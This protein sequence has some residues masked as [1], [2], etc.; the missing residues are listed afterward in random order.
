MSC[1]EWEQGIII[2]PKPKWAEFR[3]TLIK[4]HNDALISTHA[5]ACAAYD[6][7][8]EKV[9]GM[10]GEGRTKALEDAFAA[11]FG[12][13]PSRLGSG[14]YDFPTKTVG[15]G[16]EAKTT[17]REDEW[18]KCMNVVSDWRTKEWSKPKKKDLGLIPLTGDAVIRLENASIKLVNETHSVTWSVEENNRA[19]DHARQEPLAILLFTLLDKMEWTR[20]SGGKIV[21]NDEYS[22][23]S[24]EYGG[25]A[26]Y[27]KSEYGPERKS[28]SKRVMGKIQS[29]YGI[30]WR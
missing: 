19:C 17:S 10:R 15:Y 8:E 21:G 3:K 20:G 12:G 9:K 18:F 22:R 13:T 24:R 11:Y 14:Y 29:I 4:A 7:A 16:W 28:D 2:I 27:V 5:A 25:G 6:F 23:D 26:N 30:G 1:Y